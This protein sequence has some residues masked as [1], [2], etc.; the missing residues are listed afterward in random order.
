[1]GSTMARPSGEIFTIVLRALAHD[2]PA[3]LRVRALLKRI[4]RDHQLRCIG[5]T[6]TE[7]T[8]LC[9]AAARRAAAPLDDLDGEPSL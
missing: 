9:Q 5:V 7:A 2:V 8:D 6:T 4:L 1:M 3:I